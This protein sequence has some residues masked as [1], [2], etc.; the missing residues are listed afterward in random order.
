MNEDN[1]EMND[2]VHE[3]LEEESSSEDDD[4]QEAAAKLKERYLIE[5]LFDQERILI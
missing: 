1:L 3:E 4:E 2:E 5:G